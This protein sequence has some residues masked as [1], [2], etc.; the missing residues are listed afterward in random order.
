M[1]IIKKAAS[2]RLEVG[3]SFADACTLETLTDTQ[4]YHIFGKKFGG[5]P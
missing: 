5:K 1:P 4:F 2:L 3:S